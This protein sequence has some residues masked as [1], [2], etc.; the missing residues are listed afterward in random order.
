MLTWKDRD[1]DVIWP[2]EPNAR[3]HD[4]CMWCMS[5]CRR[6]GIQRYDPALKTKLV[7][8]KAINNSCL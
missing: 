5:D 4:V 8:D 3:K 6:D 2:M 7:L 1:D